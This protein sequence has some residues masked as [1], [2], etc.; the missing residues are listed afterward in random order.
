MSEKEVKKDFLV[1]VHYT[2][3]YED[4]TVFDSSVDREPLEVIAGAGLLIKG[5]DNAL[6]GMKEG[7]E[8]DIEINPE[9]GYGEHNPSLVQKVPKTALGDKV[10]DVKVG[11]VLGM[12]IPNTNHTLPVTVIKIDEDSLELDANPPM[13]G[14]KLFFNVKIVE[15][16]EATDDDKKKFMPHQHE[17][18]EEDEE[19]SCSGDCSSCGHQH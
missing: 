5:F 17:H 16:R 2:G 3:K 8:K 18:D 4:G 1:K 12:Q 6:I 9:D 13:A 10:K 14:K 7:E 15:T 19:E 11:M